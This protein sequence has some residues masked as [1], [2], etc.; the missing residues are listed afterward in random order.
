MYILGGGA[1][2]REEIFMSKRD[3]IPKPVDEG[4]DGVYSLKRLVEN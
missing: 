3:K 1:L 4:L 2:A